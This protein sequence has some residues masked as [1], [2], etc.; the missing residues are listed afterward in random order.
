MAA[1]PPRKLA[2]AADL[3]ELDGDH[4]FEVVHGSLVEKAAPSGEHGDAQLGLGA[5]L[6]RNFHRRSG[7]GVPGGWWILS[8]VDVEF[9]THDIYRPDLVGWRRER[10]PERPSGRPILVRPDWVCEIISPSNARTDLLT[11]FQVLQKCGVPHYWTV[12]PEQQ[13]LTVH[14]WTAQGYLVALRA[15]KGDLVRAEPFEAIELRVGEMF[16]EEE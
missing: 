3:L 12:D 1:V 16:G 4:A 2:T 10:M 8:E 5:V 14:R 13:L 6:R 15:T 11:K 7:G 9:D